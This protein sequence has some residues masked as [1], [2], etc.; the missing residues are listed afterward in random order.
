M[1]N[2]RFSGR[3]RPRNVSWAH[4]RRFAESSGSEIVAYIYQARD[5]IPKSGPH[6]EC[7]QGF[8]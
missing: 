8:R 7:W 6:A 3:A 4:Q 1:Q 2:G 5:V